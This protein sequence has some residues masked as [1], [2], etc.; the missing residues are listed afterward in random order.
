MRQLVYQTLSNAQPVKNVFGSRIWTANTLGEPPLVA[1][2]AIPFLIIVS[3]TFTPQQA[4]QRTSRPAFESFEIRAYDERGDYLRI[5][6]G[7][8]AVR[9]ALLQLTGVISPSGAR[10]THVRW[11]GVG[12]D[13]DDPVLDMIFR[14]CTMQFLASQPPMNPW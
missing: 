11:L 14:S 10:C 3:G 4:V 5:D 8:V 7:L 9:E 1:R 2:P 12:P 6:G 13:S